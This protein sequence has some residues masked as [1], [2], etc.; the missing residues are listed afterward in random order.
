MGGGGSP[1]LSNIL[2][3][4]TFLDVKNQKKEYQKISKK[5]NYYLRMRYKPMLGSVA[6]PTRFDK[7]RITLFILI[8]IQHTS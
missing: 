8:R 1:T 6:D 3:N 7:E 2:K 4:I 5:Y